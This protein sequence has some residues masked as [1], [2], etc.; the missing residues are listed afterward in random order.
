V[1]DKP[2]P[3]DL[4]RESLAR[5]RD[6]PSIERIEDVSMK[7]HVDACAF[8]QAELAMLK[9]FRDAE[10]DAPDAAQI[11]QITDRL[12]G[13]KFVPSAPKPLQTP[14]E[15]SWI[16]RM[17]GTGWLRPAM[18]ATI[19]ALLIAGIVLQMRH[20]EPAFDPSAASGESA[21][22]SG[23]VTIEAPIGDVQNA[24][25]QIRWHATPGAATYRVH[26]ME[27]DQHELWSAESPTTTVAIPGEI[28]TRIVPL[29]TLLIEVD[30]F[31]ASG[32][33]VSHSEVV[34]FRVL[35]NLYSH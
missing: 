2:S 3:D 12:R 26:L 23:T 29:K 20:R 31:D 33:K 25:E 34:R 17:F 5:T 11:A 24:P 4:L 6:C 32:N 19:G 30:A 8:C 22:R 7:S 15:P 18:L 13:Q 14:H 21:S 10:I 9:S 35:Q 16:E 28:R 27:V 1:P